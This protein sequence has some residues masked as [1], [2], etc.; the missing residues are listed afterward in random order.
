MERQFYYDL[1]ASGRRIP[2]ATHL[3]LHERPDPEAVLFDGKRLAEVTAEAARRFGSPLAL[4]VM[5]LTIEKDFMLRAMGVPAAETAAYHFEA[6][7]SAGQ[8]AALEAADV[9]DHPRIAA[10]CEAIRVLSGSGDLVPVGMCIG[11]FSLLTKLLRNPIVPIYLSGAG[12]DPEDSEDVALLIELAGLCERVVRASCAAQI[13][14][15]AR[16]IFVCEPAA[17]IVFFSPNQ[18]EAGSDV[19]D[20]LVIGPNLRLRELLRERGTDLLFHDCGE[21][22]VGMIESFAALDPAILSLGSTVK[23]P[24]IARYVPETTVLYGN[25]PTKKF[26][27]DEDVP[28]DAIPA[29]VSELEDALRSTGRRFIIGS[30]CDVLAM[31]GYER[32]IM[33]KVNAFCGRGA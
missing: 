7:P 27:S 24:E 4:P 28:L 13:D 9:P 1:A 14:A 26:Y 31:P 19:F 33:E 2:I 6:S 30:E 20:R 16:A 3:V 8:K 12:T 15:G 5:D 17:N 21:L 10:C 29:M 25:L 23:L 22:T 32:T 18:L 11:P